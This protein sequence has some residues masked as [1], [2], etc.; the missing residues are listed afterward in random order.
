M[1]DRRP[2]G[3]LAGCLIVAAGVGDAGAQESATPLRESR[4]ENGLEVVVAEYRNVP[5]A[6]VLVAVRNGA[7]TQEPRDEG[8]AHLYEHLLFRAYPGAP[9]AF[10][11]AVDDMNGRA[12]GTTSEEVVTYFV[13][14]PSKKVA[15][16]V[17]LLARLVREARFGEGDVKDERP[18]VLDELERHASDPAAAFERAAGRALWG[19]AWSRKDVGGDS[20]SL[21]GLTMARLRDTWTRYYV[22]NNAA[23]IVTG[24]VAAE[25]VVAAA[26]EHFGPWKSGPDPFAERPIPTIPPLKRHQAV[27]IGRHGV[28]NVTVQLAWHGPSA[29]RDTAATYAADVL[30]SLFN[31]PASAFQR[32]LV[33]QGAFAAIGASYRTLDHVGPIV[34]QGETSAER[35]EEAVLA[36]LDEVTALD[37]LDSI[38]E[39][40]LASARKARALQDALLAERGVWTASLLAT[41]W[42]SAGLDYYGGYHGRLDAVTPA[43]LAAF[44]RRYI[45]GKP[46]IIGV[47]APPKV[48]GRVQAML[49]RAVGGGSGR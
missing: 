25:Q 47:L 32:R 37:Q 29:R 20:A 21:A 17:R 27:V 11:R 38:G 48:A 19:E 16:A 39:D 7:F 41:W 13:E 26:R 4:L 6:T 30:C 10:W 40:D 5:L 9:G 1:G 24:D 28:G 35:A 45:V 14:V 46:M 3:W 8:L 23:L 43:E 49:A 31:A 15:D 36:L 44:A 12:N 18:I 34:I 42:S 33:E 22:P 2:L